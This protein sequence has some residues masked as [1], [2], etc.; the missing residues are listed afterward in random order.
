MGRVDPDEEA[1]A[2][3]VLCIFHMA[4]TPLG[5]TL[6]VTEGTPVGINTEASA[7]GETLC[8]VSIGLCWIKART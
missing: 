2:S 8:N 4:R 6:K 1:A 5:K 3:N 7:L